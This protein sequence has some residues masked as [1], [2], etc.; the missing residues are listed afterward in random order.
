MCFSQHLFVVIYLHV[1]YQHV[2]IL[3]NCDV[4]IE[5]CIYLWFTLMCLNRLKTNIPIYGHF[6][7][8]IN[9]R[10]IE[11]YSCC[12]IFTSW[13]P[14]GYF[15]HPVYPLVCVPLLQISSGC[16]GT[17]VRCSSWSTTPC[18]LSCVWRTWLVK[19]SKYKRTPH[20]HNN[21][22][23]IKNPPGPIAMSVRTPLTRLQ[24]GCYRLNA[25]AR[26][27]FQRPSSTGC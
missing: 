19:P 7:D 22:Q 15:V 21:K 9:S 24:M 4:I 20:I 17:C 12:D 23:A 18:R 13:G 10:R 11:Q 2:F 5:T 27:W 14:A 6:H 3:I 16:R 26:K 1:V 8:P 25:S